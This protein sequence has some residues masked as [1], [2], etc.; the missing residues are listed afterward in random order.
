M[1]R[2]RT[3]KGTKTTKASGR[4]GDLTAYADAPYNPRTISDRARS[5]LAASVRTFGDLSGF[6]VNT[7]TGHVV[8]GHQR[9]AVLAELDLSAVAWGEPYTCE[10]GFPDA[11]FESRERDGYVSTPDGAR[12]HV[13]EVDW[14]EPFEKAANLEANNPHIQ[15]QWTE[16]L[17][18][19][20]DEVSADVG[21]AHAAELLLDE[22]RADVPAAQPTAGLTD[23]DAIPEPPADPI[24]KPGD[25]WIMGEHRLLCGDSTKAECVEAVMQ[26]DKAGLMNTDPPYGINYD[27]QTTCDADNAVHGTNRVSRFEAIQNDSLDGAQ[28]QAFL[29][30][31]IRAAVPFLKPTAAFYLWHPML[32]EGTFFAAAAAAA[33][34]AIHRQIIW[35]KPHFIFGRGDYHWQHELCFYGWVRGNRPPFYGDRNQSSVWP[36]G[37]ERGKDHP[38]QKPVELF[39]IPIRN[40]LKPGEVCYEPFCGSGSQIIAAEQCGVKCRAIE[41]EPRYV[42]VAVRRWQNFTG[43]RAV[44]EATGEP[45]PELAEAVA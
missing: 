9:R 32:T 25:L 17:D 29:E 6:V 42:D 36:C 41:I 28:L 27:P 21:D 40:H 7:Q 1:A 35:V 38:A 18:A 43:K 34:I 37:Q 3:T 8:C 33:D 45:Y 19:L 26:G 30:S 4:N 23:P 39:T 5:G 11:R 20:L 14:P 15:G 10:L 22:L 44:L 24:T 16:Q 31:C 12:F 2:K 13:R